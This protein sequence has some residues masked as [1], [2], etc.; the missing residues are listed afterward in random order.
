MTPAQKTDF[1]RSLR[2]GNTVRAIRIVMQGVADQEGVFRK[3]DVWA[4]MQYHITTRQWRGLL[5]AMKVQGLYTP[6]D[7]EYGKVV[8]HG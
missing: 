3:A 4:I 7:R 5:G 1:Q 6:I 2:F 8:T